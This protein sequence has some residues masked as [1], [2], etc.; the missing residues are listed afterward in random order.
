MTR[1][2]SDEIHDATRAAMGIDAR[3]DV[4]VPVWGRPELLPGLYGSLVAHTTCR[5]RLWFLCS[6]DDPAGLTGRDEVRSALGGLADPAVI[7]WCAPWPGG[8]P[9]DYARKINAGYELGSAPVLFVGATDIVFTAGWWD[10]VE[11]HLAAGAQVVGT[12]DRC[13]PRTRRGHS[14][15]SVVT[16]AFADEGTIDQPGRVLHE[17]Y[18][19]E[20]VDDELIAT[21]QHRGVYVHDPGIV[22]EHRHPRVQGRPSDETDA[23]EPERMTQGR[24]LFE[25]RRALWGDAPKGRAAPVRLPTRAPRQPEALWRSTDPVAAGTVPPIDVTIICATFGSDQWARTAAGRAVPSAVRQVEPRRVIVHHEPSGTLASTRNN[26]AE[27]ATTPW[28]CFLD[29]DDV[30]EPGYMDAMAQAL[31]TCPAFDPTCPCQDGD[32]CHYESVDGHPAMPWPTPPLL[33]PAVRYVDRGRAG[34]PQVL[35]DGRPLL[36]INRAVIGTLV[37]QSAFWSARGFQDWP[38][39]ED[40]AL[41]LRCEG[42]GSAL[43]DVPDAVYRVYRNP[44]GRNQARFHREVYA[45]IRTAEITLRE[46]PPW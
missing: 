6:P 41:W 28:L 20:F 27:Q 4:L 8:R 10:R 29:A 12:N 24:A 22:V 38:M 21:A 17:G 35:N 7:V 33:V 25:Q 36:D 14:T 26:A 15:H 34:E 19:H 37:H 40:W 44:R 42:L 32:S 31:G 11:Q 43:I 45:Q 30:L 18:W 16:R 5:W 23:Q 3:L 39:Y 1:E 13:N 9:G 2:F 46:G